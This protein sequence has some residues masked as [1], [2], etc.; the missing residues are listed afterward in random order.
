MVLRRSPPTSEPQILIPALLAPTSLLHGT[1]HLW[2]SSTDTFPFSALQAFLSPTI[3]VTPLL[4]L[5]AGLC[6][7]R[8]TLQWLTQPVGEPVATRACLRLGQ[9]QNCHITTHS[10]LTYSPVLPCPQA[11][12]SQA[13]HLHHQFLQA[14]DSTCPLP[15]WMAASLPLDEPEATQPLAASLLYIDPAAHSLPLS[16]YC[17]ACLLSGCPGR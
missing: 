11:Q 13:S 9:G 4:T 6:L 2:W 15:G 16:S 8:E 12:G 3:W 7:C 17:F 14:E 1:Q 5:K 10:A